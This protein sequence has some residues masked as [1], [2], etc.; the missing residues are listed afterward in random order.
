MD[1]AQCWY[2]EKV[3]VRVCSIS[4]LVNIPILLANSLL[5]YEIS[6]KLTSINFNSCTLQDEDFD[7]IT[8][9]ISES[10]LVKYCNLGNNEISQK[11]CFK[12]GTMIEKSV[13]IE[14]LI[15]NNCKL[16]GETSMLLFNSKGSKSLKNININ[17][18]EI[19]DI[20]LVGL[21]SFI[22]NSPKIEV[23]ELEGVGGNDMGFSTLINCVKMV[24]NIKE[25][26]FENINSVFVN[27]PVEKFDKLI[28]A[29]AKHDLNIEFILTT[30]KVL[31]LSKFSAFIF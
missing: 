17:D 21:I 9:Y 6:K 31:N 16:N 10:N 22:K 11:S 19:G 20:G 2:W 24:G 4:N 12:L 8:K 13:S 7:I 29:N 5:N 25:I 18:N 30:F 15:L 28:D 1:W 26:H 3:R 23:F 14:S 27:F